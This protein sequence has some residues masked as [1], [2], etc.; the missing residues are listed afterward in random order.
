MGVY[1]CV[2]VISFSHFGDY[3]SHSHIY[4]DTQQTEAA[5]LWAVSC[6]YTAAAMGRYSFVTSCSPAAL[7]VMV[8]ISLLNEVRLGGIFYVIE[9]T[10]Y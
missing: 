4:I 8:Y 9:C 7:P 2:Y 5:L 10:E 3:I 6:I 1:L